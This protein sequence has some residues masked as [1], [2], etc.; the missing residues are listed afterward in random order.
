MYWGNLCWGRLTQKLQLMCQN[1]FKEEMTQDE[2]K[3]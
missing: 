3:L 2:I 1:V